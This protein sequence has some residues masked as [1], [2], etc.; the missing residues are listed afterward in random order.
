MHDTTY[1]TFI[2]GSLTMARTHG[3]DEWW[4]QASQNKGKGARALTQ[5]QLVNSDLQGPMQQCV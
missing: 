5:I 4:A 2:V 3:A 1:N